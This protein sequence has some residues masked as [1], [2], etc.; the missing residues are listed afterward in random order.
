MDT[1]GPITGIPFLSLSELFRNVSDGKDAR[2]LTRYKGIIRDYR[3]EKDFVTSGPVAF[4][5]THFGQDKPF[6][7][8]P[9]A[10]SRHSV[11][12]FFPFT[13]LEKRHLSYNNNIK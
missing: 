5:T 9:Q 8:Q 1:I 7:K 13:G 3:V 2:T 4:F 12:N 10:D 11:L 6:K